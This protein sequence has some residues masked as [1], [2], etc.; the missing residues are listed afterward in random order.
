MESLVSVIVTCYNHASYIQQCLE[1]IFEQNYKNIELYVFNDGSTDN[2]DVIIEETLKRSPYIKTKYIYQQNIGLVATRNKALEVIT[3]E[4][5][6]FVDSDNFLEFN[7]ISEMLKVAENSLADIVYSNVRNAETQDMLLEAR[8][9]N[10]EKL[11]IENYI[12]SCSLVRN[13]KN[14][15]KYD[16]YLNYKKLEDY[17]FFLNL[18]VNYGYNA[19][20]CYSTHLNYRVLDYSMSERN[21]LRYYYDVYSYILGKYYQANP[22]FAKEA[23]RVNYLRLFDLA[24]GGERTN[25]ITIYFDRGDGFLDSNQQLFQ[26]NGEDVLFAIDAD[27]KKIRIDLTEFPSDYELVELSLKETGEIVEVE[28]TNGFSNGTGYIFPAHDPQLIYNVEKYTKNELCLRY[29]MKSNQKDLTDRVYN[30]M[31]ELQTANEE[32]QTANEELKTANEDLE[33]AN[34]RLLSIEHQYMS[35]LNSRRWTIPTKIINFFRRR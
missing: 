31:M 10:L 29:S 23:M 2:S 24:T 16:F 11:Y 27:T 21:N 34:K 13:K 32:L 35:M 26:L 6:L 3:G 17:D 20:P 25:N 1:S 5:F 15:P 9:F 19:Q 22:E 28:S 33:I 4:Y 8:E 12:E 7:Y 18:I 30:Y 14:I